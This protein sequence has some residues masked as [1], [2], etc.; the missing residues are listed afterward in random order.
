LCFKE[1]A[2]RGAVRFRGPT[3]DVFVDNQFG[4]A[5]FEVNHQ[6]ELC[7]PAELKPTA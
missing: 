7:M 2:A 3:E 1:R 4:G 5:I 6:K